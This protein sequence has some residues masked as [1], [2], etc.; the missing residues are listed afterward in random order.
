MSAAA[1]HFISAVQQLHYGAPEQRQA[2]DRWLQ[3]YRDS[4][5]S[6]AT[7]CEVLG[8]LSLPVPVLH[9]AA[10]GIRA[11]VT[12]GQVQQ[13]TAQQQAEL[14][15]MLLSLVVRYAAGASA[16]RTQLSL[17]VAQLAGL[18]GEQGVVQTACV[19]LG[20]SAE[21]TPALAELLTLLAEEAAAREDQL[22]PTAAAASSGTPRS[23][24]LWSPPDS[25]LSRSLLASPDHRPVS[26][27]P[28]KTPAS[29]SVSA[30]HGGPPPA[31]VLGAPLTPPPALTPTTPLAAA[32]HAA[33]PDVIAFLLRNQDGACVGGT[34][35]LLQCYSR[36][37]RFCDS[38][39]PSLP[40]AVLAV[41]VLCCATGGDSRVQA[42]EA[43]CELAKVCQGR[44]PSDPAAALLMRSAPELANA[45]AAA[46]AL[47]DTAACALLCRTLSAV[48]CC[49]V[50]A[51]SS[52]SADG[53]SIACVI[54]NCGLHRHSDVASEAHPFWARLAAALRRLR[55]PDR[56]SRVAAFSPA[57]CTLLDGVLLHAKLPP[58]SER[59]SAEEER[60]FAL[61]RGDALAAAARDCAEMLGAD[62]ALERASAACP[63]QPSWADG[64]VVLWLAGALRLSP[65]DAERFLPGLFATTAS[66]P[67]H[68]RLN[69]AI[70]TLAAETTW[71]VQGHPELIAPVLHHVEVG[72]KAG[73]GGTAAASCVR[74]LC[75]DCAELVA[76]AGV[77]EGLC[78]IATACAIGAEGAIALAD[79]GSVASAVAFAASH[80]VSPEG[81]VGAAGALCAAAASALSHT[82]EGEDAEPSPTAVAGAVWLIEQLLSGAS[83]AVAGM[84]PESAAGEWAEIVHA[85]LL[86]GL[87]RCFVMGHPRVC[88]MTARALCSAVGAAS[89][90]CT[91]FL[92]SLGETLL[93]CVQRTPS[94]G[95]VRV[96]EALVQSADASSPEV[97]QIVQLC[98]SVTRACVAPAAQ[99]PV[100]VAAR[101][102]AGCRQLCVR[103]LSW[104]KDGALSTACICATATMSGIVATRNLRPD[105]EYLLSLST[106][107]RAV[108]GCGVRA[109]SLLTASVDHG[110]GLPCGGA[111]G[112]AVLLAVAQQACA[113]KL[114]FEAAPAAWRAGECA[115]L[116]FEVL[117]AGAAPL[118][119]ATLGFLPVSPGW[120]SPEAKAA[121]ME[122]VSVSSDGQ[123]IRELVSALCV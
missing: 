10:H 123:Q 1:T 106:F 22:L 33:A 100:E 39:S 27:L 28:P 51:I 20:S 34:G 73:R 55:L 97:T 115:A 86:P 6:W 38:Q 88:E 65:R 25:P 60:D 63:Q 3:T 84:A 44:G 50:D 78:G 2:A 122:A 89:N 71:W 68:W 26:P 64:E 95:C 30:A 49:F 83:E 117:G 43:L 21:T 11:K 108:A 13:L 67:E 58:D 66:L 105:E 94:A 31:L 47:S 72:F 59:W 45:F 19:L 101:V 87:L 12:N 29:A 5:V 24:G 4:A 91:R 96:V 116:L 93:C 14:P 70:V 37:L 36:W 113:M 114:V 42:C 118:I 103:M 57:L 99:M 104:N 76:V 41:N 8:D 18:T 7:F 90:A 53:V 85:A 15:R 79:R 119:H 98:D 77:L 52:A 69:S 80:C 17:A 56:R 46:A 112:A 75:R 61:L 35:G 9:S 111:A 40:L 23:D 92:P 82:L 32:A 48:G 109:A 16:V 54:A 121:C 62:T 120:P 81:R 110:Y 102:A 107:V 74:R